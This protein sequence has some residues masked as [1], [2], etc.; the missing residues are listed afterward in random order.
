M[1]VGEPHNAVSHASHEACELKF[2][3]NYGEQLLNSH[4]SHE[5]C[6]LKLYKLHKI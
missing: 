4:A 1:L 5:A 3:Y 6:E 2:A